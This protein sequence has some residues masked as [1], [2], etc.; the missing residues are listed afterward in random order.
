M[1]RN[2]KSL[3]CFGI[4]LSVSAVVRLTGLSD[5]PM[6][7]DE[8]VHGFK[9]GNM[10]QGEY[11][12][13]PDEYH[14][15]ALN[16]L[17]LPVA[18]LRNETHITNL[19]ES[20][21]RVVPV[22]FSLLTLW[23]LWKFRRAF[24]NRAACLIVILF[25]CSPVFFFYSRYY[26]QEILLV[27]FAVFAILSVYHYIQYPSSIRSLLPGVFLGLMHATK[28]TWILSLFAWGLTFLIF[29]RVYR[30]SLAGFRKRHLF[31]A[32]ATA[33]LISSV[34][35][36][37]FFTCPKGIIDSWLT[38]S[39]YFSRGAGNTLHLH[40][41]T[42]YFH[43]LLFYRHADGPLYSEL[44]ILLAGIPGL[45]YAFK[46]ITRQ[47]GLIRFIAIYTL[48]LTLVY[49]LLP[50]KTPWLLLNFWLGWIIL[51]GYGL[52]ML[53]TDLRRPVFRTLF[54]L[55]CI[56]GMTHLGYQSLVLQTRNASSPSNPWTYA[57]PDRDIFRIGTAMHDIASA[58]PDGLNMHIQIHYP[59]SEY[60]PLPW[61]LRDFTR[62]GWYDHVDMNGPAAPVILIPPVLESDLVE[63]LYLLPPPGKR[64]LYVPVFEN[65]PTLRPGAP[66]QIYIRQSIR[67]RD[68]G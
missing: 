21:L 39:N 51:A 3:L 28:E 60:W 23:G 62:I 26:I 29:R 54:I 1:N 50:Y 67:D 46:N 24:G 4:I 27:C 61:M 52:T 66:V 16:I 42:Y 8:A 49:V 63:K 56:T 38:Y 5:R 25:A 68:Y 34:F 57:Q 17:T 13:D 44:F 40:P 41:W 59:G 20:T 31:L 32:M 47:Q 36:S 22:L 14:G 6:H 11:R 43:L 53:Y 45:G 2:L 35:Y 10:L 9:L 7:T 37:N 33:I 48:I 58:H 15:P 30:F 19:S 18:W 12:Y 55:L 64:H 65:M